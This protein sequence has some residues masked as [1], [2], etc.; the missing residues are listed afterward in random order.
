MVSRVFPQPPQRTLSFDLNVLM[1]R[2]LLERAPETLQGARRNPGQAA[3]RDFKGCGGE[4]G[5]GCACWPLASGGWEAGG[6][7][8][9]AS[10]GILA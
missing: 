8:T 5:L 4:A 9:Q 3:R 7:W 10:K 6:P 2:V 1:T